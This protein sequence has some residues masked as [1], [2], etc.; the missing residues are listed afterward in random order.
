VLRSAFVF[1]PATM[2]HHHHNRTFNFGYSGGEIIPEF[3]LVIVI[4]VIAWIIQFAF[5]I[6]VGL[7]RRKYGNPAFSNFFFFISFPFSL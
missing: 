4:G 7:S 5:A 2:P 6:Q 1:L 3:G